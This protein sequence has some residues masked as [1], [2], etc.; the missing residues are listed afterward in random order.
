[1]TP[2]QITL[3]KDSWQKVIPIAEQAASL[4]YSRLFE[5]DPSLQSLF[6]GDMVGQGRKL[7]SMINTAVINLSDL[8]SVV[9]A[10]QDLGKRHVR[11]GVEASHYD[12]VGSA[13][14]WTLSTGLGDD[15]TQ[16]TED[17]WVKA[18]GT[19]ATVMKA[20]AAQVT[21]PA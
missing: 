5:L 1:M 11:Y 19:I 10:I 13:L 3:V 4:F 18:Y 21:E 9:P 2:E 16:E 20:A 6:T 17:A 14:L 8:E 15:F 7:T 12:T